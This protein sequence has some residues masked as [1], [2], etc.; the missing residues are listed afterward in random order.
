MDAEA[1]QFRTRKGGRLKRT[2]RADAVTSQIKGPQ[3]EDKGKTKD[4]GCR[5]LYK[6]RARRGRKRTRI[7]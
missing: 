3:R 6:L 5:R 7:K 2:K 4:S 1:I